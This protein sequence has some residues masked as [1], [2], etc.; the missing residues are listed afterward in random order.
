MA[1]TKL[2]RRSSSDGGSPAG[3][4]GRSTA[5]CAATAGATE[6]AA[7]S[8][9]SCTAKVCALS[10]LGRPDTTTNR[11]PAPGSRT[12]DSDTPWRGWYSS[13]PAWTRPAMSGGS[14]GSGA[15]AW[16]G[17]GAATRCGG[18]QLADA[19]GG[20][21]AQPVL[22]ARGQPE[23]LGE[24]V[25]VALLGQVPPV[26]E[27][28]GARKVG[29]GARQGPHGV[30]QEVLG[31]AL[32]RHHE[33]R[34]A[35]E[36]TGEQLLRQLRGQ[37]RVL[38]LERTDPALELTVLGLRRRATWCSTSVSWLSRLSTVTRSRNDVPRAS[39]IP[40]ARNTAVM[41]TMW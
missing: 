1:P 14:D 21:A 27:E 17:S 11:A 25:D 7:S 34:H 3:V 37:V 30:G 12:R 24:G 35:R 22:V 18:Q 5:P 19:D 28:P 38:G 20:V 26:G 23:Q 6:S 29:T 32:R 39:P 16:A 41:L 13:N 31:R 15:A 40:S 8:S 36:L 2:V 9:S 10:S 4:V 33:H